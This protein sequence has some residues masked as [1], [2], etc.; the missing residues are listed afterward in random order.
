M[1]AASRVVGST[2]EAPWRRAWEAASTIAPGP[3][4]RRR[5]AEEVV[6]A[7]GATTA[8]VATCPPGYW[9]RIQHDTVPARFDPLIAR[10]SNEFV[11]RIDRAGE[12]WAVALRRHGVVYAPLSTANDR[13]L[14]TDLYRTVLEP[15][16]IRSWVVAFFVGR[17]G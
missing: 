17:A 14:A 10:I 7:A 2:E 11:H 15:E 4:W 5:I 1:N 6:R 8:S 13:D 16:G 12:G 9:L 3:A